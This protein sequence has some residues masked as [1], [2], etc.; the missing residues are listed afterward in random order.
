MRKLLYS[1]LFLISSQAHALL[2][3]SPLKN[4]DQRHSYFVPSFE[5]KTSTFNLGVEF[6]YIQSPLI[7]ASTFSGNTTPIIKGLMGVDVRGNYFINDSFGLGVILP[8]VKV[9]GTTSESTASL[10]PILE[11]R[12][13]VGNFMLIPSYQLASQ[14]MIPIKVQGSTMDLP[15]GSKGIM[16]VRGAYDLGNFLS[17][18]TQLFAGFYQAPENK[19]L[20]IDETSHTIAGVSTGKKLGD[21]LWLKGDLAVDKTPKNNLVDGLVYFNYQAPGFTVQTGAGAD[22]TGGGSSTLKAFFN[23]TYNFGDS[24]KKTS[25]GFSLPGS[26]SSSPGREIKIDVPKKENSS[27]SNK[28]Q[29]YED[30]DQLGPKV[31][32]PEQAPRYQIEDES[33]P[34]SENSIYN[35][36]DN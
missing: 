17:L 29:K 20:N 36:E 26:S 11:A 6:N 1:L 35:S 3:Q 2:L 31:L 4:A 7:E 5:K 18:S 32:D 21:N 25:R 27:N 8:M 28:D 33:I 23:L 13:K 14:T 10:G 19:F 9:M 16:G 12:W 34:G 30:E 22:L 15:L 24:A